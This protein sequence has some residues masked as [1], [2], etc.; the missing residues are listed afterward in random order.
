MIPRR[1]LLTGA[2]GFVARHLIPRLR[3]DFPGAELVLCGEGQTRLDITDAAAV[4]ALVARVRPEACVHLAAIVAVAEARRD[5]G[6]AWRVNVLGTL[7]LAE[8]IREFV[9]A[10]LLVFASSADIYGRSFQSGRPLDET[11][12]AAPMNAYGATK[13]AADLAL[14]AMAGD[15]LRC[16]RLRPFNHTGAGQSTSLAVPAFARQIARVAAGK[17]APV[18]EVGALDPF[19]DFL[20]VRDVCAAYSACIARAERLAPGAVFNIAS[21][22]PRRMGDVLAQMLDLAGVQAEVTTAAARLRPS[23]IPTA[24][25]D[26][27]AARSV[28]G[29]SPVIAWE[30][31]LRAVL[32]DW[33]MRVAME[34]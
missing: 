19:R 13:A 14:G 7:A 32:A 5:P 8:A 30:D 4:R 16:V 31:T 11:A 27:G 18:L 33:T 2:S 1:I 22:T 6:L 26:A 25:G 12:A 9:P 24:C 17:Q 10:C 23:D 21:G 28:L 20:D 3:A 34:A 29:W 15:G